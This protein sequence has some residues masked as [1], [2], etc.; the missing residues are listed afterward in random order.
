MQDE[1]PVEEVKAWFYSMSQEDR[2]LNS[3]S[4]LLHQDWEGNDVYKDHFDDMVRRG[5]LELVDGKY[6]WIQRK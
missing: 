1:V 3:I 5:I 2:D 6:H 4:V